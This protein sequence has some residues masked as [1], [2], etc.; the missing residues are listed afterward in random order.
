MISCVYFKHV[1]RSFISGTFLSKSVAKHVFLSFKVSSPMLFNA[2]KYNSYL[3]D[4]NFT[5]TFWTLS[6]SLS[7]CFDKVSFQTTQ[8]CSTTLLMYVLYMCVL[9]VI[10]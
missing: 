6:S 9:S 4:N 5:A 1:F 10:D 2:S 3:P 7:F 8:D